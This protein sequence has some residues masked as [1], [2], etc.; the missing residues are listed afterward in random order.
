MVL[1]LFLLVSLVWLW[2]GLHLG[3]RDLWM[4]VLYVIF[5]ILLVSSVRLLP[6]PVQ[7][8]MLLYI[9]TLRALNAPC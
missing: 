1:C 7:S 9:R 4:L 2:A 8:V 5:N 3:Y 6:V